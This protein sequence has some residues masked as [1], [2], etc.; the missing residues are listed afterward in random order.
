MAVNKTWYWITF[1]AVKDA[2]NGDLNMKV[3]CILSFNCSFISNRQR[4]MQ[5]WLFHVAQTILVSAAVN[6]THGLFAFVSGN[7][8]DRPFV[9]HLH[10][11][12]SGH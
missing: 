1:C 5:M 12:C 6:A 11:S 4:N 8:I 2:I 9:N 10:V 3:S 7:Q